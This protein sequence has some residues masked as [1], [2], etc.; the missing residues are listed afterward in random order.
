MAIDRGPQGVDIRFHEG[1]RVDPE[2]VVELVERDDRIAFSPPSTLRIKISGV[3]DLFENIA[4][5]LRE[6]A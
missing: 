5:V 1:A 6:I 3:R 4:G 2:R